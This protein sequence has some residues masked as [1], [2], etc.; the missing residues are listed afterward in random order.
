M[1]VVRVFNNSVVLAVDRRGIEQILMGRGVGFHVRAGST[2]DMRLVEK[3]F[4]PG[5][6]ASV[7]RIVAL[8][9]DIPSK[10]LALADEVLR[11]ARGILG[12]GIGG[13]VLLPLADHIS[14]AL[15]RV[16]EGT[17]PIDYPLRWEVRQ[18]Y[19]AEAAVG[20]RAL[21]IIEHRTG[22]RLPDQEA[23]PLALHF[24]N[25]QLGDADVK[26]ALQMT[27]VLSQTLDI[28][29][30]TFGLAID[31]E[32]APVARFVTHLRFLFAREQSGR[33]VAGDGDDSL[34]EALRAS[35]P[36]AYA[37]AQRIADLFAARF[38]RALSTDEVLYL[39]LHVSR[40]TM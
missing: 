39:T 28:V 20:K 11:V 15:R 34:L 30:S 33:I 10:H 6:S 16:A 21:D 32:S 36:D 12:K 22:M 25:A 27:Q 3:R 19:P 24:V 7:E 14:F 38:D 13:H 40:L 9:R 1:Q 5:P 2:V 18:L 4:T 26:A 37:A 29:Q 31:E 23:I 8:L 17:T 35:R